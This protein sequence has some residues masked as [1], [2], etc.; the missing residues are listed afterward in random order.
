MKFSVNDQVVHPGHGAGK[1]TGTEH[2]E[3]VEGLEEYYVIEFKDKGLV[4]RIPVDKM[5]RV[6]IRPV[7]S[8]S[9]LRRVR[10][11]LRS[12][13][14]R[15][16]TNY[17]SRQARI[18]EKLK[19]GRP[20]KIAEVIRDLSW[21]KQQK[22]LSFVEV[23]LLTRARELLESEMVLVTEATLLE[24]RQAIN[25]LLARATVSSSPD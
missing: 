16:S 11:T 9:R 4:A 6:G 5:E 23:D 21:R 1:I 19:S 13:P 3:L 18:R 22:S 14:Q 25:V 10:K 20:V 24:V 15:L 12:T 8:P 2:L 17:Q 7:I